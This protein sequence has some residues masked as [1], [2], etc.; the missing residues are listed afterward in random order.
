MRLTS[1]SGPYVSTILFDYY[2]FMVGFEIFIQFFSSYSFFIT[3]FLSIKWRVSRVLLDFWGS[4][5][6]QR[7]KDR[8]L[9][10]NRKDYVY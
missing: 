3:T 10:L 9:T 7:Q 2:D 5:K 4:V 8:N 6:K 1:K